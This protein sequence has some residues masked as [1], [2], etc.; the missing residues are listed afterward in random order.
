VAQ[1]LDAYVTDHAALLTWLH[2]GDPWALPEGSPSSGARLQRLFDL[3]YPYV[4][5]SGILRGAPRI[6]QLVRVAALPM[7][8]LH[9]MSNGDVIVL[10]EGLVAFN[11]VF[12]RALATLTT[13]DK[14]P[15]RTSTPEEASQWIAHL[16]DQASSPRTVAVTA[17]FP[18]ARSQIRWAE[19]IAV[20]SE[21]FVM[22]HEIAH[23]AWGDQLGADARPG[24]QPFFAEFEADVFGLAAVERFVTATT[25]EPEAGLL[26]AEL[27]LRAMHMIDVFKGDIPQGEPPPDSHPPAL[28]RI[29]YL[30]KWV[31]KSQPDVD[32]R[33]TLPGSYESMLNDLTPQVERI[34]EA[35][36]R[37]VE[38]EIEALFALYATGPDLSMDISRFRSAALSLLD[39]SA[40]ATLTALVRALR[41]DLPP[42]SLTALQR[43]V[44]A[45]E[46][47]HHLDPRTKRALEIDLA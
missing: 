1:E 28:W 7:P 5:E 44:L 24:W 9:T 27:L 20:I 35:E 45:F 40:V 23:L 31:Q 22:A 21:C 43:R 13:W 6:P 46:T 33:R 15:V 18:A 29:E 26:A 12:V 10:H 25:T 47:L 42:V 11:Y 34:A 14:H 2:T 39:R 8:S 32:W 36:R 37:H 16:V 38:T 19:Q 41:A 30:R 3:F 4:L 17:Q